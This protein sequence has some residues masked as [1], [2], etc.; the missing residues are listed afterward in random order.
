MCNATTPSLKAACRAWERAN[1][2]RVLAFVTM[3]S[4][5]AVSRPLENE[6]VPTG[7]VESVNCSSLITL[8]MS[9]LSLIVILLIHNRSRDVGDDDAHNICRGDVRLHRDSELCVRDH[10][11]ESGSLVL[12]HQKGDGSREVQDME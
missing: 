3:P 10:V 11:H 6:K 9:E 7:K 5:D 12:P 4:N 2:S 8:I 1:S